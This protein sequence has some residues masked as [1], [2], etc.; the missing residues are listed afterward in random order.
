MTFYVTGSISIPESLKP[1]PKVYD[2]CKDN[3]IKYGH[4]WNHDEGLSWTEI[5]VDDHIVF[6]IGNNCKQEQ[7]IELVLSL[8]RDFSNKKKVN[9]PGEDFWFAVGTKDVFNKFLKKH[10][11]LF[12]T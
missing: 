10:G 8:E 4:D 2:F 7:F 1:A 3:S 9:I 11:H 12:H 5:Y 6:Q